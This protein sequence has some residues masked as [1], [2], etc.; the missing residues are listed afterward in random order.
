MKRWNMSEFC[1]LTMKSDRKM[2]SSLVNKQNSLFQFDVQQGASVSIPFYNGTVKAAFDTSKIGQL[3]GKIQTVMNYPKS[4]Y[5]VEAYSYDEPMRVIVKSLGLIPNFSTTSLISFN[6]QAPSM[7]KAIYNHELGYMTVRQKFGFSHQ[8]Y[9][10][11]FPV[12]FTSTTKIFN[13]LYSL[14]L[15]LFNNFRL[16]QVNFLSKKILNLGGSFTYDFGRKLLCDG[17]Y[18][19]AYDSPNF[20]IS[21]SGRLVVGEVDFTLIGRLSDRVKA[22]VSLRAE[23]I[24]INPDNKW[25]DADY[26]CYAATHVKIDEH[27]GFRAMVSS[28]MTSILELGVDCPPYLKMKFTASSSFNNSSLQNNF[29]I[30]I[31]FDLAKMNQ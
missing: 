1:I 17:S 2:I 15:D 30:D 20:L 21:T 9:E 5:I 3:C 23:H 31:N 27:A 22:G 10:D 6:A 14:N 28:N 29:G 8:K 13:N 11:E 7:V 12:S 16:F 18:V 26:I 4:Q 25:R 24:G 19:A